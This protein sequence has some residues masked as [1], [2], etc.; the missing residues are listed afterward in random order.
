[1]I[2]LIGI[3]VGLLVFVLFAPLRIRRGDAS[4]RLAEM[5]SLDTTAHVERAEARIAGIQ[6]AG[7]WGAL[8][9]GL[10]FACSPSLP[11]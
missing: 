8:A 4:Q 7:W 3:L 2:T 9:A 6:A 11:G 10:R 1:M 5:Y